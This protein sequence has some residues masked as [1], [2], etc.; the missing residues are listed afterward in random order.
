[1]GGKKLPTNDALCLLC[2]FVLQKLQ[3]SLSRKAPQRV[4]ERKINDRDDPLAPSSSP[5]GM[6]DIL[7]F[8]Q[9]ML[10]GGRSM[11]QVV[12]PFRF[13]NTLLGY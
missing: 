2:G 5:R 4:A 13:R 1:M 12:M 11:L 8:L 9:L 10:Q 7:N 3:R 6:T